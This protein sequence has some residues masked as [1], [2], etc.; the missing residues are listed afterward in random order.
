MY[1]R[2]FKQFALATLVLAGAASFM[3]IRGAEPKA[4]SPK[5]GAKADANKPDAKGLS[6]FMR[7][8]LDASSKILEGLAIEDLALVE[9]GA[10]KL[11]EMSGAEKFRVHTDPLYRQFSADFQQTTKELV[12]SANDQNL[13][14]AALKWMDAT[15][16]CIECHRYVRR[17]LMAGGEVS[18]PAATP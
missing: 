8:K 10:K 7:L 13:D 14:R 11:N 16:G 5:P 18:K 1:F 12:Q 2:S 3:V 15:M 9:E 17:V 6:E 4:D